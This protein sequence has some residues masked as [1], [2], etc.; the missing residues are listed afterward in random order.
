MRVGK[1]KEPGRVESVGFSCW[2]LLLHPRWLNFRGLL[3]TGASVG[4][5]SEIYLDALDNSLTRSS[6]SEHDLLSRCGR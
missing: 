6:K 2:F 5:E 4:W 1:L 3:P